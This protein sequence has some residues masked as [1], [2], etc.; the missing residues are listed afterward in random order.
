MII[1]FDLGNSDLSFAAYK[2]DKFVAAMRTSSDKRKSVDEFFNTIVSLLSSKGISLDEVEG[3]ILSSVVPSLTR[4]VKT[5]ISR[6]LPAPIMVGPGTKSGLS[7]KT[8]NTFMTNADVPTIAFSGVVD[9]PVNPFTGNW[10]NSDMKDNDEQYA[11]YTEWQVTINNGNT[12]SDPK[13][14]TLSNHYVFEPDNWT[15]EE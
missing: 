5:A 15:V 12:F 3:T 4:V 14:I 11:M 7:I 1:V 13:R 6:I 2:D 8:D 9:D 10:I